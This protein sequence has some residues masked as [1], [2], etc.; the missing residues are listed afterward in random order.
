MRE[1]NIEHELPYYK[2]TP[3]LK[4]SVI[5]MIID[6]EQI[7]VFKAIKELLRNTMCI[8]DRLVN[9]TPDQIGWWYYLY[10]TDRLDKETIVKNKLHKIK[11]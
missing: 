9:L 7:S 5:V 3:Q 2:L 8:K 11:E 1:R 6:D 4:R 10:K